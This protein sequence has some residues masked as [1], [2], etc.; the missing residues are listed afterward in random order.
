MSESIFDQG[1]F[2]NPLEIVSRANHF[3]LPSLSEGTSRVAMEALYLGLP[4]VMRNM[5]NN[6]ELIQTAQQGYLFDEDEELFSMMEQTVLGGSPVLLD[7]ASL[8]NLTNWNVQVRI[9]T[10]EFE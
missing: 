6:F 5:V 2:Y 1:H 4:C 8:M 9:K 10:G 7:H 3:V